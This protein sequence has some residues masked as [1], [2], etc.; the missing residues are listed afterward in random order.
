[1]I[2]FKRIEES[3]NLPL[4]WDE[5][6]DNYF[7]KIKFLVHTETYNPCK[8]RYYTCFENGKMVSAAVVYSLYL[9]ILTFVK[10]KSPVKM[11]IVGIPCSVSS[12]GIFGGINAIEDL[13]KHICQIEKGLVLFLN[14]NSKPANSSFSSG[15]TLPTIVFK[16]QYQNWIDYLSALRSGYRRR[17]N[18]INREDKD[19]RFEKMLCSRFTEEMFRLYIEVYKRSSSKLERLTFDFFKNL[20][21]EFKLTVCFKNNTIIGWNIAL[22]DRDNFY[23]FLGGI[24]YRY[25]KAYNT[26]LRLLTAIMKDGIEKGAHSIDL[27]QT[28]EIPKIRIGGQPEIRYMEASHSSNVLNGLLKLFSPL[29]EYK[30]RLE[31]TKALK[32]EVL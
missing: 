6:S 5:L 27:G 12:Q 13:K 29:L 8:Q 23:F 10:I 15:K 17:L 32:E 11:N 26:Y 3:A 21:S 31:S 24:D 18:L 19:L 28:A 25:N 4:E 2:E 9:D 14:L 20:P 16:N 7:Q 22:E 1:M 30:R